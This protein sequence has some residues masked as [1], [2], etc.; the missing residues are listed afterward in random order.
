MSEIRS[1][2][3]GFNANIDRTAQYSEDEGRIIKPRLERVAELAREAIDLGLTNTPEYRRYQELRRPIIKVLDESNNGVIERYLVSLIHKGFSRFTRNIK[4]SN[5]EYEINMMKISSDLDT[6]WARYQKM[7]KMIE[8]AITKASQYYSFDARGY[9]NNKAGKRDAA[10]LERALKSATEL[11]QEVLDYLNKGQQKV[12]DLFDELYKT[13]VRLVVGHRDRRAAGSLEFKQSRSTTQFLGA[14]LIF[15]MQ[16]PDDLQSSYSENIDSLVTVTAPKLQNLLERQSIN[17]TRRFWFTLQAVIKIVSYDG[18]GNILDVVERTIPSNNIAQTVQR[19]SQV[20]NSARDAQKAHEW[21]ENF[22]EMIQEEDQRLTLASNMSLERVLSITVSIFETQIGAPGGS[23]IETPEDL[24]EFTHSLLNI[25]NLKQKSVGRPKKGEKKSR[26]EYDDHCFKW[27][28]IAGIMCKR[29]KAANDQIKEIERQAAIAVKN[30][31][32]SKKAGQAPS[33]VDVENASRKPSAE[34]ITQAKY[35][36]DHNKKSSVYMYHTA[37]KDMPTYLGLQLNFE[38]IEFPAPCDRLTIDTFEANN[39]D[40]SISFFTHKKVNVACGFDESGEEV[41][42]GSDVYEYRTEPYMVSENRKRKYNID[43]LYLTKEL[44]DGSEIGHYLLIKDFDRIR[45]DQEALSKPTTNNRKTFQCSNRTFCCKRF[46]TQAAREAHEVRCTG[47][48]NSDRTFI[49]PKAG[50]NINQFDHCVN[51]LM[52]PLCAFFD[53]EAS[54]PKIEAESGKTTFTQEHKMNSY[55]FVLTNMYKGYTM[56]AIPGLTAN[57]PTTD[58]IEYPT[59]ADIKNGLGFEHAHKTLQVRDLIRLHRFAEQYYKHASD[60]ENNPHAALDRA[61]AL[62]YLKEKHQEFLDSQ[63]NMPKPI[64]YAP[65]EAKLVEFKC[66]PNIAAPI[67]K[68]PYYKLRDGL[69]NDYTPELIADYG[70]VVIRSEGEFNTYDLYRI[71]DLHACP[72]P[73]GHEQIFGNAPQ[74][75]KFDIDC[76]THEFGIPELQILKNA[77]FNL[78]SETYCFEM[79]SNDQELNDNDFV[80]FTS[81]GKDGEKVKYSYHVFLAPTKFCFASVREAELFTNKLIDVLPSSISQYIDSGVNSKELQGLRIAGSSKRGSTRVK[82]LLVPGL[83]TKYQDTLVTNCQG[84]I[85]FNKLTLRAGPKKSIG[86]AEELSEIPAIC[87]EAIELVKTKNYCPGFE[88][89]RVKCVKDDATRYLINGERRQPGSCRFCEATHE[90]DRNFSIFVTEYSNGIVTAGLRCFKCKDKTEN[91]GVLC[92]GNGASVVDM[93]QMRFRTGPCSALPEEKLIKEDDRSS[94]VASVFQADE[95]IQFK[96]QQKCHL[97][98]KLLAKPCP[99]IKEPKKP[100]EGV[101]EDHMSPHAPVIDH[102][103]YSGEIRGLVHNSCNRRAHF[104]HAKLPVFVHNLCGYDSAHILK[105]FAHFVNDE[106]NY[107]ELD[108]QGKPKTISPDMIA[109]NSEKTK[110]ITIGRLAFRDSL[111]FV[112][113][114]LATLVDNFRESK[115]EECI[116]KRS[117]DYVSKMFPKYAA[118]PVLRNYLRFPATLQYFETVIRR[119]NPALTEADFVLCT[120]KGVYPYSYMDTNERMNETQLP[121]I[122]AFI[123]PRE[124]ANKVKA[125]MPELHKDYAFAQYMFKDVLKC[126]NMAEYHMMYN[127]LDVTLLADVFNGLRRKMHQSYGIDP[128]WYVSLPSYSMDAWLR[129][130]NVRQ[131]LLIEREMY[132]FIEGAKRGGMT[133]VIGRYW[134]ANNDY[135]DPK[136]AEMYPIPESQHFDEFRVREET[137]KKSFLLYTDVNSLYPT[138]MRGKMP[139]RGFRW[140]TKRELMFLNSALIRANNPGLSQEEYRAEIAGLVDWMKQDYELRRKTRE[141]NRDY[142]LDDTTDLHW[143]DDINPYEGKTMQQIINSLPPCFVSV[144]G[145]FSKD[146]AVQDRLKNLPPMPDIIDV[147]LSWYSKTQIANVLEKCESGKPRA[148]ASK[149]KK[150]VSHLGARQEYVIHYET[151]K[152]AC[153]LGFIVTKVHKYVTFEEDTPMKDYIEY[154]ANKRA[155]AKNLKLGDFWADMWKICMNALYGKTLEDVRDHADFNIVHDRKDRESKRRFLYYANNPRF[156]NQFEI[157]DSW[158]G[159]QMLKTN[160][161][162]NKPVYL[163]AAILDMSKHL[164]FSYWYDVLDPYYNKPGQPERL[165]LQMIDTDSLFFSV[166]TDDF[167]ADMKEH[168]RPEDGKN[169]YD[170][171]DFPKEHP[172]WALTK[173]SHAQLGY[174]KVEDAFQEILQFAAIAPKCYSYVTCGKP[175]SKPEKEIAHDGLKRVISDAVRKYQDSLP[176]SGQ[177]IAEREEHHKCKGITRDV[178]K[179]NFRHQDMVD[180]LA[181]VTSTPFKAETYGFKSKNHNIMTYTCKKTAYARL[182]TKRYTLENQYETL[183]YGHYRTSSWGTVCAGDSAV[184]T[185]QLKRA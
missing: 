107:W 75:I 49:M 100:R 33:P 114:P 67:N 172:M 9:Y 88:F 140:N 160:V 23:Y 56:E 36:N 146:P 104:Y 73:H 65:I 78:F 173:D 39:P 90:H 161:M 124:P 126:K 10:R 159:V 108:K 5:I 111:Q 35:H 19:R 42:V 97:C 37:A 62:K 102:D 144:S 32:A 183:P 147:P 71:A 179:Y 103:H 15:H 158:L 40:V 7:L 25:E 116:D 34:L 21:L 166:D 20:V 181:A 162:L 82:H 180:T 133:N 138:I 98:N 55:C 165:R 118:D 54:L 83:V 76:D 156:C 113:A 174:L 93:H 141:L 22:I 105:S 178:V 11:K 59:E 28:V 115:M 117:L 58:Y 84:L 151:L 27:S 29:S 86:K 106:I 46:A 53:M 77:L 51:S 30:I 57:D 50:E 38:G 14:K 64:E 45:S 112:N 167:Y 177:K 132:D 170:C 131:E 135:I 61:A 130:S 139:T 48:P 163:G 95:W 79:M 171:K 66:V 134:R 44:E 17:G 91:L 74:R 153:R 148:V 175:E 68:K 85:P 13:L 2:L 69:L 60:Y 72:V 125:K 150:L 109:I 47:D 176:K 157:C 143:Q 8:D 16:L 145:Y 184:K 101:E 110:C 92:A 70:L 52:N 1:L 127:T 122:E 128:S 123:D 164:M 155:E 43:L 129:F 169:I 81:C 185:W 6:I 152:Q 41:L 120:R 18:Q 137:G 96:C 4:E 168:C 12:T 154:V 89:T 80:V 136:V 31:E 3:A 99:K 182:D 142:E 149:G 24:R 63:S 119:M 121:S 87:R 94:I 26:D